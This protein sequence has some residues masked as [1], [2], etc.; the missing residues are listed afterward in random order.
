MVEKTM[1]KPYPWLQNKCLL[2]VQFVKAAILNLAV[3]D[4]T[5]GSEGYACSVM[6]SRPDIPELPG[7]IS[8]GNI[9]VIHS[10]PGPMKLKMLIFS[11]PV[12]YL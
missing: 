11:I 4:W 12:A 3:F 10:K 2:F 1:E 5:E 7:P 6:S 9:K 8:T